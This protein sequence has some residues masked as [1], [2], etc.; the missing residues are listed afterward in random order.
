M[1][2][3]IDETAKSG[4]LGSQNI[5]Q[6]EENFQLNDLA[7]IQKFI[8]CCILTIDIVKSSSQLAKEVVKKRGNMDESDENILTSEI[9]QAKVSLLTILNGLD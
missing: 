4:Y 3:K 5:C 9:I 7:E 8:L 1:A 2:E 6:V